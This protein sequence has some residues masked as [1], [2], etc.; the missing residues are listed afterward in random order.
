M[1]NATQ[2]LFSLYLRIKSLIKKYHYDIK[3]FMDYYI[4]KTDDEY[5]ARMVIDIL[6]KY[7]I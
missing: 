2:K 4:Y 1:R 3:L 6:K 5:K 7:N